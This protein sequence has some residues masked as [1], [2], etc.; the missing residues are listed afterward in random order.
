[1]AHAL[2]FATAARPRDEQAS[3]TRID[4]IF[5]VDSCDAAGFRMEVD[6]EM[7]RWLMPGATDYQLIL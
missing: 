1:V 4:V 2:G 6:V 3:P 7:Q 5:I